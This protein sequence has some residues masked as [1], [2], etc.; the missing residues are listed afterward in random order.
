VELV[1]EEVAVGGRALRI[2][3]PVDPEGLI[4]EARFE[5]DEFMPYWAQLWPSGVALADFVTQCHLAGSRVVELGAGL[6]LPSIAAALGGASVLATDWAED[7]LAVA[8]A[9]ARR[10]GVEIETLACSWEE[11]AALLERAPFDL[12]LAAD[13]L[14]ERRNVEPLLDLLPRLAPQVLLA[15]PG[16]PYARSFLDGA[17]ARWTVEEPA[18]RIHRMRLP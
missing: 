6:G 3:R 10:N 9:N 16:R 2:A 4:D 14:Y 8:A 12:V 7:S 11:P 1:E 18:G 13:V 5:T 15:E 17:R